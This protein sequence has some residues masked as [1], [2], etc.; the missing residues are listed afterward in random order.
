M[1]STRGDEHKKPCSLGE[2]TGPKGSDDSEAPQRA[3][4]SRLVPTHQNLCRHLNEREK[5]E[6]K[7]DVAPR[8][9]RLGCT[10]EL[11]DIGS[12]GFVLVRTSAAGAELIEFLCPRCERLHESLAFR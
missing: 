4:A 9:V 10:G 11:A 1:G 6:V 3:T 5:R 8:K 7:S 2:D 12:I